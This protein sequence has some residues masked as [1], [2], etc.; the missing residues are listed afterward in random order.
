MQLHRY[1]YRPVNLTQKDGQFYRV[2]LYPL[3]FYPARP[4]YATSAYVT[5]GFGPSLNQTT[6]YLGR[7]ILHAE[8]MGT[9]YSI[10]TAH[11]TGHFFLTLE[12]A[13]SFSTDD[14]R[15]VNRGEDHFPWN[16]PAHNVSTGKEAMCRAVASTP[17]ISTFFLGGSLTHGTKVD[18]QGNRQ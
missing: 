12:T 10:H 16:L 9:P 3:V 1:N 17:R 15:G 18:H 13:L 2:R 4:S 8:C 6:A 5:R 11:I 7:W 14:H